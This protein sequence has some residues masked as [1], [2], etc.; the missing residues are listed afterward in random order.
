MSHK[1]TILFLL[2]SL[3]RAILAAPKVG[4]I[5]YLHKG[6]DVV[7]PAFCNIEDTP[8]WGI[9]INEKRIWALRTDTLDAEDK[10]SDFRLVTG[11]K[12]DYLEEGKFAHS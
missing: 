12:N 9:A 3:L 10:S 4:S 8:A 6:E 2:M 5:K 1:F 11:V 7:N